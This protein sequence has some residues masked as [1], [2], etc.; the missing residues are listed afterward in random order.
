MLHPEVLT[1]SYK[2]RYEINRRFKEILGFLSIDHFSLDL[3]RPDGMMIFLS[4]TPSH[5]YEVCS[6]GYGAHDPTISADYYQNNEFYWWHDVKYGIYE[7]EIQYI[8]EVKHGFR[9]GFMLVRQWDDFY[10]IY[11]FATVQRSR[12]FIE[13]VENAIDVLFEMGDHVYNSMRELYSEYTDDF[14]PPLIDKFY[15]Y[16]GGKPK[17][18]YSNYHQLKSGI[19]LPPITVDKAEKE[20][21]KLVSGSGYSPE[22]N[23]SFGSVRSRPRL[24]LVVDNLPEGSLVD[25]DVLVMD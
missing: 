21:F 2:H 20:A 22:V 9:Y 13:Y 14:V 6:K 16:E 10:L 24:R 19:Y 12:R 8:R 25:D 4:G 18:R 1:I 7:K 5:G 17:P 11:S 3:V 15:P 23:A